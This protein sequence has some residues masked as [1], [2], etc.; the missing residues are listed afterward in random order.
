MSLTTYEAENEA[1]RERE[2][3]LQNALAA[4]LVKDQGVE[5]ALLKQALEESTKVY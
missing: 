2:A 3:A 1:N 5:D 4:S